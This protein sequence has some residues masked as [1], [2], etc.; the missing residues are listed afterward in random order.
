MQR[1]GW[2]GKVEW[3][4]AD[5]LSPE[6]Y[7]RHLDK[8]S[9]VVH[10]MGIILEADYKSILQGKESPV[11]GLQKAVGCFIGAAKSA[12]DKSQM[13]YQ[14]MNTDSAI[15]LAKCASDAKIPTFVYISAASGAPIVPQGYISS[16]R[17]AESVI[18]SSLPNLRSIF[19]R[20]TFM[21]DSSR[22]ISVPIALGGILGSEV[23]AL[24]GG[25][26]SFL[27]M[28]VEKPVKVATVGEAVVES[29]DD[30]KVNGVVGPKQIEVL[31]TSGWRKT[32]L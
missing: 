19:V 28:M 6:S 9:A 8:A 29:I 7:S 31:A 23:N 16:K 4:K 5:L 17:E 30:S 14:T 11:S 15:R 26:L 24:M 27:G 32:M 20:P 2:A 13:T 18:L 10:S 22:K 21:Y 12:E 1:P 25:K 3:V